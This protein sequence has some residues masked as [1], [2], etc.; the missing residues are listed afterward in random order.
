LRPLGR[1]VARFLSG[2]VPALFLIFILALLAACAKPMPPADPAPTAPEPGALFTAGGKPLTLADLAA[3]LS[4]AAYVLVGET[5]TSP[6]DHLVQAHILDALAAG[7]RP[8]ALGLE[9]AAEDQQP[10]LDA[11]N[12][13][14]VSLADLPER[15]RWKENWGFPFPL[16]EPLFAVAEGRNLPVF[17]L[18]IPF[19]VTRKA[20]RQGQDALTP[21][22]RAYYPANIIPVPR[23]QEPVLLEI[24]GQHR[25]NATAPKSDRIQSFFRTQA[26]WD[27]KMAERAVAARRATN[28]PVLVAAG[29]GHVENGWGIAHRL[30]LLDPGASVVLIVPW[31]GEPDRDPDAGNYHFYCPPTHKSRLGMLLVEQGG[32]V[33]VTEVEPGSRAEAAGARV[34]DVVLTA[35]GRKVSALGDLHEAG[36]AAFQA[37]APLVFE[38]ERD[39]RPAKLDFGPLG[40]E[41]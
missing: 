11:F 30:A 15:L 14:A 12:T 13:R 18:N 23:D 4:G 21:E 31:R 34:G 20:M 17:G 40:Q 2:P 38:V 7:P 9:M 33:S 39:G 29:D 37:K 22:E 1:S 6:C 28:R 32:R 41:R 27:T 8:P 35:Q 26:A 24:F 36:A 19:S 10:A 3:R 5:H 25:P 16:Y